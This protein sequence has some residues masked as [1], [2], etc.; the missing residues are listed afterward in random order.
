MVRAACLFRK[1]AASSS[2]WDIPIPSYTPGLQIAECALQTLGPNVGISCVHGSLGYT[3]G[4]QP[5][6]LD[7]KP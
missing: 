7:P 4:L 5:L 1:G 6:H 3:L 2:F